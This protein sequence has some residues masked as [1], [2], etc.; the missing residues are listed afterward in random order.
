MRKLFALM[1]W[2]ICWMGVGPVMAA[3]AQP[4]LAMGLIVKL[5]GQDAAV[6]GQSL[7]RL[8]AAAMPAANA[9]DLRARLSAAAQRQR[10]SFLMRKPTAFAAQVIHNGHPVPVA[11]AE[12]EAARL[13]KDPDVEWV[14]VNEMARPASVNVDDPG[15]GIQ[16]WLQTRDAAIGRVAVANFP[17]AWEALS[18]RTLS[19][20]VVAVLDTGILHAPDLDGRL[21]PGYDFVSELAYSGDGNGVDADPT[22]PGEDIMKVPEALR[23]G[24][25]VSPVSWHGLSVTAMLAA[26]TGNMVDGAGALAPLPGPLVLPVRVGGMCGAMVSDIIE[27]MLWAAGVDYNGSPARNLHP[28]RVINLSFGGDGSCADT[29]SGAHDASWLYRQTIATLKSQGV[30]VVASAGNGDASSGLGLWGAT[31]PANCAGVLAVTGLN[32]RGYKARYANLMQT[33]GIQSFGVAVASGDIDANDVLTDSGIVTLTNTGVGNAS[34]YFELRRMVGTSLASPVVAGVAA[35]M[36]AADPTLTV[37]DLLWGLTHKTAGF[38]D[39]TALGMQ[40]CVSGSGGQGNCG[41]TTQTCGAGMLDAELAVNWAISHAGQGGSATPST[42][43]Q[44]ACY[45]NPSRGGGSDACTQASSSGGGAMSWLSLL[46]LACCALAM[47]W[48]RPLKAGRR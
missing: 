44:S 11:Q 24:C 38:P 20:V 48:M 31:R 45:F 23:D 41:C 8:Q 28:A 40:T 37:D 29:G 21:L 1:L 30:L 36:L 10:V 14:I 18:N 2:L 4:S 15:Y 47:T 17:P 32:E 46:A 22:D 43:T 25:P 3:Q 5:K 35:L 16:T 39:V 42:S 13:R 33:D 34:S 12:A 19:P 7:V 9:Q 26:T 27:G 6:A